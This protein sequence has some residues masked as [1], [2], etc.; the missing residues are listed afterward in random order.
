MMGNGWGSS[1]DVHMDPLLRIVEESLTVRHLAALD[2]KMADPE[3]TARRAYDWMRENTFDAAPLDESEP[4]RVIIADELEP[5]DLPVLEQA[6]LID[7]TM[8]VS[9][10]LSLADGITRL[11]SRPFYFILHRDKLN[12]IVTRADLQRPAVAMVLFSMILASESAIN[13]VIQQRLGQSWIGHLSEKER[14]G[15]GKVFQDRLRHN[16]EITQLECVMLPQRLDLLAASPGAAAD[17]GFSGKA[18]KRWKEKLN[19]LRDP[20][21][22]GGGLLDAEPDPLE[23][24]ELFGKVRAFADGLWNLADQTGIAKVHSQSFPI[25]R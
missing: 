21:A 22:H 14:E 2:L 24:I 13:V 4:Y 5:D 12:G 7:S 16:T 20:L 15:V 25:P 8:L 10:D 18:F 17:L 19:G 6:R 9:A 11:A 3:W 1:R 23:A